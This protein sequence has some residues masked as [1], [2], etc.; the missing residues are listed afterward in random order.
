MINYS[1]YN[2][3]HFAQILSSNNTDESLQVIYRSRNK[4][5]LI[6]FVRR[7]TQFLIYNLRR[8]L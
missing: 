1:E 5:D 7:K 6:P 8:I 4:L 2:V 3:N